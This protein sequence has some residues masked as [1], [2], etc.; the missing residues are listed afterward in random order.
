MLARNI[1]MAVNYINES[2]IHP[3]N[4]KEFKSKMMSIA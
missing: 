2:Q 3:P 4:V 1:F